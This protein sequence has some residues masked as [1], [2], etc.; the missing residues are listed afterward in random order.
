MFKHY[1]KHHDYVIRIQVRLQPRPATEMAEDLLAEVNNPNSE[2]SQLVAADNHQA[3]LG[4]T[5]AKASLI[6][7][8]PDQVKI[9]VTLSVLKVLHKIMDVQ[10]C[11]VSFFVQE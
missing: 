2:Y 6:N 4:F 7:V 8:P 1:D 5:Y 10:A 11:I 3:V 9:H